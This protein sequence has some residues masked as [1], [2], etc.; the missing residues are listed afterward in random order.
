MH[1]ELR[2]SG[3]LREDGKNCVFVQNYAFSSPS[4]AAVVL[5][6]PANGTLEWRQ[7]Q[8]SGTYKDWEAAQLNSATE[9][10]A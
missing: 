7:E 8:G 6:R 4:A 9:K 3:V 2:K 10:V 1:D 5:G